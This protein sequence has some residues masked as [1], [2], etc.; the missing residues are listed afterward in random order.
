VDG[1][2]D[3]SHSTRSE[4]GGLTAPLLLVTSLAKFWGLQHKCRYKWLT[5]SKA[6][7]SKVTLIT[8]PNPS[9]PR[10][11][12]DD[13]DYVTAIKELH[14]SLGGRRLRPTW[15]KG[16]QDED[17]EYD[18]LSP[19]AKLNVDADALASDHFWSGHGTR[20]TPKIMHFHENKVT[21]AINGVIYPTRIDDQIRYHINGSYLKD[22]LKRKNGWSEQ[23]WST[24]DIMAFGRH[25][26]TLSGSKRVQHMKFVHDLQAIGVN[27]SRQRPS[28]DDELSQCPCCCSKA[29]TQYHLVHCK[30]NPAR[31]KAVLD[32]RKACRKSDGTRFL[33]IFGDILEQWLVNPEQNPSLDHRLNPFLRHE[34]FPISYTNLVN[35]ALQ[36]Q[37]KIGWLNM[38]RG[39]LTT[40]WRQ[41]ASTHIIDSPEGQ[42]IA[43]RSDGCNRVHRALKL[44]HKL[45][46]ELWTGRNEVLH[47]ANQ[48]QDKHRLSLIDLEITKFHSEGDQFYCE[49]SLQKILKGSTANKRR[50]LQRVR[51]SRKRHAELHAKQPR[52]TKFFL[53]QGHSLLSA[54]SINAAP[55]A[56][57]RNKSTQQLMSSFLHERPPHIAPISARNRTT[58]Q[59]LTNF[60]HER[61]SNQMESPTAPTRSPP[62]ST[63]EIG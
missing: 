54:A 61:A 39:F 25:F 33:Q 29:E 63:Q 20:P 12:P 27:Q 42:D 35:E 16:H 40:K 15:I 49:T 51:A 52:I 41:L 48:A 10:R 59:L 55:Q 30:V 17:T 38:L 34:C 60:L 62:P 3:I 24:I 37:G 1:P 32:L 5:D 11:Y 53:L 57:S 26:K 4:L 23:L 50:W 46:N 28:S 14:K 21:I 47:G 7:I 13:V 31:A 18:Q 19:D 9:S 8:N 22:F 58:Q 56:S 43:N 44:M 45:T 2:Y 6:A 36:E